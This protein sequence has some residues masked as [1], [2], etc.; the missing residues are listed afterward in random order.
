MNQGEPP[1]ENVIPMEVVEPTGLDEPSPWGF[2]ATLAFSLAVMALFV[3]AQL[4]VFFGLAVV[5]LI[6]VP[7]SGKESFLE[8]AYSGLYLSL[9]TWASMPVCLALIFL[10]VKLRGQLSICDYLA[11]NRVSTKC[12]LGWMAT[13]LAFV[14]VSDG[15]TWLLGGE[16][17]PEVMANVYRT[18]VIVPLLWTALIIAAPLF[19]EVFFRGFV[20]RGIQQSRLGNTGAVLIASL[21]WT[22]IH[23]QYDAYQWIIIFAGGILLGIA[24]IRSNSIYVPIAMHSL[25]NLIATIQMEVYLWGH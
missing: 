8:L 9:A 16:I 17:V 2:W 5:Q 25:M 6:S 20:F 3:V 4:I 7:N 18:A 13:L 23:T 21:L 11:L 15:T 10:L 24:R 19:E 12:F 1:S 22:I 14:V